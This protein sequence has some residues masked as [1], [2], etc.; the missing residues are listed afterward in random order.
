MNGYIFY[1]KPKG[2]QTMSKGGGIGSKRAGSHTNKGMGKCA[3]AHSKQCGSGYEMKEQYGHEME[4]KRPH[5]HMSSQELSEHKNTLK[6][7]KSTWED[8]T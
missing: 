1:E 3:G 8:E 2:E 5:K 4:K 7:I 6:N